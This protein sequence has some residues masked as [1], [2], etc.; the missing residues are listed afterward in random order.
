MRKLRALLLVMLSFAFVL[1]S[2]SG[3]LTD[4]SDIVSLYQKNEDTFLQAA[5]NGDYS[6]VEGISGVRKV[7]VREEYV[8]VQCGG[9]GFGSNTHYY[10][11]FYSADD[12]KDK[13]V[14]QSDGYLY[15]EENGDNRYYIEPL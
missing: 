13:L 11:I 9:T 7:L 8:D 14:E 6:S 12:V 10:G 3:N 5:R 15:Q 1:T 4:K 2:C